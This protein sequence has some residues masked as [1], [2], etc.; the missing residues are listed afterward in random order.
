MSLTSNWNAICHLH[1][2]VKVFDVRARTLIATSNANTVPPALS[3]RIVVRAPYIGA[4]HLPTSLWP[5]D[6]DR[7]FLMQF[8]W[9]DGTPLTQTSTGQLRALASSIQAIFPTQGYSQMGNLPIVQ[10]PQ[11]F[12]ESN[13][14][15]LPGSFTKYLSLAIGL[16][17]H[18]TQHWR[19]PGRAP[20]PASDPA[21]WCTRCTLGTQEDILHCIW[22]CPLS[23][24]CWRW[25]EMLLQATSLSHSAHI[26]L[27]SEHIF[28]ASPDLIGWKVPARE[29]L[30][31]A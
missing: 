18:S 13:L 6:P 8:Q 23:Q 11:G 25:C 9:L 7:A 26:Q 5:L 31:P 15:Q 3:H 20:R 27:L 28:K 16:P 22:S 1:T 17:G 21:T 14:D 24:Q 2:R 10:H 19:A 29:T 12:M 30:A 4:I